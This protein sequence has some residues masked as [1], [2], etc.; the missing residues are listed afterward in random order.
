MVARM[1]A[2]AVVLGSVLLGA[3]PA[4]A[5][6]LCDAAPSAEGRAAVAVV[7]AFPAELAPL[8]AAARVDERVDVEGRSY[9]VGELAGVRVVLGLTGIGMVNAAARTAQILDHFDVAAVVMSGVAGSPRRIG[10]VVVPAAWLER[11]TGVV[12]ATD[13]VLRALARPLRRHVTLERCTVVEGAPVCLPHQ[14]AIFV[15]DVG[16]SGDPFAGSAFP[17]TPGAGPVLGCELP[18]AVTADEPVADDMETA[19]VGRVATSRGVP[20]IA[21][22]AVSDGAGDPLGLPGFPKQFFAYYPLAAANAAT[23]TVALLDRVAHL[24]KPA[25][26][27]VCRLLARGAS[28]RAVRFLRRRR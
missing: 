26:R 11:D 6:T 1:R 15:G 2:V 14:P 17:C 20:W 4:A 28:A 3:A 18:L 5:A 9:Y 8:V 12:Y 13:A 27:R 22:R 25:H 23:G 10:D 24:G 7:S 16:R 21:L 19:A